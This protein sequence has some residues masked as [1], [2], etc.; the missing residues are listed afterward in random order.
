LPICGLYVYRKVVE[1]RFG[2]SFGSLYLGLVSLGYVSVGALGAFTNYS[3]LPNL[4]ARFLMVDPYPLPH[5]LGRCTL[6]FPCTIS[7]M[8]Y[9][10]YGPPLPA[11]EF[12]PISAIVFFLGLLAL[13]VVF[14]RNQTGRYILGA[15]CGF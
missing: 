4:M 8:S 1:K 10:F 15:L 5:L 7:D 14:I 2:W 6:H 3:P 13:V 12:V 9:D 11:E